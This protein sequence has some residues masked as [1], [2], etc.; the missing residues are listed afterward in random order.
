MARLGV[1]SETGIVTWS[2]SAKTA[3]T[4]SAPANQRF[5]FKGITVTGQGT[6]NTD[7]PIQI[8][9]LTYASITGGTAGSVTTSKKQNELGETIQTTIAGNYSAE[10]TYTTGV[11]VKNLTCH[12][13]LGLTM[14]WPLGDEIVI[15]GGAGL[16][17]RITSPQGDKAAISI[18]LE[19]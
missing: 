1:L 6:V 5:V 2:S 10:P 15:K 17:I 19:E 7:S 14:F 8:E 18:E 3:F 11:T 13:Q 16:G 9:I 12:P 4:A